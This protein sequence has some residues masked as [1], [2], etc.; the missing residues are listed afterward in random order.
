MGQNVWFTS[1]APA[2][3]IPSVLRQYRGLRT[4]RRSA[5]A[6]QDLHAAVRRFAAHL[7]MHPRFIPRSLVDLTLLSSWWTMAFLAVGWMQ[8]LP[9]L[10]AEMR[11]S[12][13]GGIGRRAGF[14]SQCPQGR[15]GSS[16]LIRNPVLPENV[17]QAK[18]NT[19]I[20]DLGYGRAANSSKCLRSG[21][22]L[23]S[24]SPNSEDARVHLPRITDASKP[25][26][27]FKPH[28]DSDD[29]NRRLVGSRPPF[30]RMDARLD[31]AAM[32]SRLLRFPCA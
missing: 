32:L 29:A 18:T 25:I 14:R 11:S 19:S 26:R 27:A 23:A 2:G 31:V 24:K 13:C 16:P 7:G 9:A 10:A 21:C 15:G 3:A 22:F 5:A 28:G 1:V 8:T 20:E 30:L 4:F 17:I 6:S 12:G